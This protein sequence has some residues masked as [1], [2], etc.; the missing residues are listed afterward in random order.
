M[1]YCCSTFHLL[2]Y[3]IVKLIV[4]AAH[5]ILPSVKIYRLEQFYSSRIDD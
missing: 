1:K 2:H 5:E 3:L 4:H